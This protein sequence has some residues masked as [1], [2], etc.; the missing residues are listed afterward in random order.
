MLSWVTDVFIGF[1]RLINFSS[2]SSI[3]VR[4][5]ATDQADHMSVFEFQFTLNQTYRII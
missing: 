1:L 5:H 3:L 2:G 4:L